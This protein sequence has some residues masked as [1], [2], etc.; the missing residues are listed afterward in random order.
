MVYSYSGLAAGKAALDIASATTTYDAQV[1]RILE[2]VT[3]QIDAA[4]GGRRFQ[5]YLATHYYTAGSSRLLLPDDLLSLTTLKT[6]SAISGGVRTYGDV[7]ATTDYDLEPYNAPANQE[8][9]WA[10]AVNP[11]GD[12]SFPGD[13]RGVEAIGLWAYWQ[14]LLA[15]STLG[16]AITTTS[17]TSITITSASTLLEVLQTILIDSEQL[18]I[19]AISGTT[20]TVERGMNGTTAATHLNGAAVSVYRYPP[21]VTEACVLQMQRNFRTELASAQDQSGGGAYQTGV[22]G[23]LHPIISGSL[24]SLKRLVAA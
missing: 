21:K 15:V 18:Y 9:Y 14:D 4:C 5:P 11:D 7:W 12:Y 17:A 20:V 19:T 10:I 3:S 13:A 16:A 22:S 24:G 1:R 6:L 23:G 2:Q 8:P